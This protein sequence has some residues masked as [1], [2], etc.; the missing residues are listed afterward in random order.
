MG[1]P[2]GILR[3]GKDFFVAIDSDG[4]VFDTMEIK[5]KEC[6]CPVTIRHYNLQAASK[7]VRQ[8]WEFVNLYSRQRGTNRFPALVAVMDLLRARPEV[9]QRAVQIPVLKTLRSWIARESKLGNPALR[10]AANSQAELEDVLQWSEAV[11]ASVNSMVYG[12]PPFPYVDASLRKAAAQADLI[13]ASSTPSEALRREWTEHGLARYVR[14]IA[15][16]ETGSKVQQ[17]ARAAGQQY[18]PN[19]ML[20][21]GDALGDLNAARS[22]GASF[23]PILPGQEE[24]SWERFFTEV[25]DRFFAGRYHGAYEKERVAELYAALP[26]NP[27]WT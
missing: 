2:A 14:M 17:L 6:F 15:G 1:N 7:Y 9:Q 3:K 18:P 20:M 12:V 25:L 10:Q 22:A 19:R 5:H 27:P 21:I 4:C 16:Q 24:L 23:Y 13:V 11:N 26:E 8:A